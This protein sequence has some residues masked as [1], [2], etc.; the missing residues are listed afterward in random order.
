VQVAPTAQEQAGHETST[1]PPSA[2]FAPNGPA[3]H[4]GSPSARMHSRTAPPH[5][6]PSHAASTGTHTR[7]ASVVTPPGFGLTGALHEPPTG[8]GALAA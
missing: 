8:G 5:A 4:G 7:R 2:C 1:P 3:G 6:A